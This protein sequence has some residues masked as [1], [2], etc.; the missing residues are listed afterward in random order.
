M[1]GEIRQILSQF[2]GVQYQV[3]TFLGDRI[4]ETI[5]GETAPVVINLFGDDLDVLDAKAREVA[6][7]LKEVPGAAEVQMKSPPGVPRMAIRL[8]P[9]RLAQFGFRPLEVLHAIQTAYQGTVV[10]Q[11]FQENRVSDVAVMLD[12]SSRLD[13]EDVGGLQLRSA[14]GLRVPLRELAETYRTSGRY[15]I[16]HEGARRRQTITCN[17]EG[18]DVS[19]FVAAAK[20]QLAEKISFPGGVYPVFSGAAEARAAAQRQLLVHSALAAAGILLLLIV[21]FGNWRNLSLV[22]A[23]VP[24]ALVGGVLAVYLTGL[25]EPSGEAGLT[26]GSLVGFVTLFG[27]TMRNSIMM[28][29]HYEHLVQVEGM[30]WGLEAAMRGAAERLLPILM[31]AMVTGLGLLP[32]ALGS[33][34]AGREI[35][36]PMAI[37]I[38]GG[39]VTSTVL[40]LLVLP[41]LALRYGRFEAATIANR[42]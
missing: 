32:L 39:L 27:I 29:A 2:P 15:S 12:E 22:L 35:E 26:I 42:S 11:T 24:F 6:R 21:V 18:R 7:V 41:T 25:L 31:T 36:G 33:G 3:L 8:R 16:L 9:D 17:S 4:G 13:P 5:T 10:A 38:L 28:I 1:A 37:V 19:A 14:L 30:T 23:N 34:E 20:R 40:N